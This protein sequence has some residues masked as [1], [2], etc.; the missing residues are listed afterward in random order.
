M[1]IFSSSKHDYMIFTESE[2]FI[3]FYNLSKGAKKMNTFHIPDLSLS[4]FEAVSL[5]SITLTL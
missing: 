5:S 3:T 1:E 4:H 2:N